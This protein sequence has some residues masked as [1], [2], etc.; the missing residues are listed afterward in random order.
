MENKTGGLRKNGQTVFSGQ[1]CRQKR[2]QI[3]V[4]MVLLLAVMVAAVYMVQAGF[5]EHKPVYNFISGPWKTIGGMME[6]GSWAK[7][8]PARENHPNHWKRM[9]AKRGMDLK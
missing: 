8:K 3:T 5:K 4:E 1:L 7:R 2:G 9:Y 6:S